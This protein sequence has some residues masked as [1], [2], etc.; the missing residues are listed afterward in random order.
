[1]RSLQSSRR[2]IQL[3]KHEL[4]L[5]LLGRGVLEGISA[6]LEPDPAP[7]NLF[8]SHSLASALTAKII[9]QGINSGLITYFFGQNKR[10]SL[11]V[12]RYLSE[13]TEGGGG[14]GGGK[15]ENVGL[16]ALLAG[17]REEARRELKRA[18]AEFVPLSA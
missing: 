2:T 12:D 18:A 13:R 15:V 8:S 11:T 9:F 4:P 3:F 5:F 7:Q 16:S 17:S 14:R 6:F 1:M 10:G